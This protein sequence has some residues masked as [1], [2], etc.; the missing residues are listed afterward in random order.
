MFILFNKFLINTYLK[1]M[2]S[3]A[4]ILA[5]ADDLGLNSSVNQAILCCFEKG[6]INSTSLLTNTVH[7][8]E[9]V[10]LI[11]ANPVI[12]RIGVHVNL[13]GDKPVTNFNNHNY[14][15]E[16][17]NWDIKKTNKKLIFLST[18]DKSAFLKEI[19]AQIDRAL[20]S[21]IPIVHLDS[22]FHLHTLPGFY[23]L[24]LQA[25]EKYKIKLRLAQTYSEGNSFKFIYRKYINHKF[26]ANHINYSDYFETVDQF[27]KS[28]T[29]F[30]TTK[31]I[32]LMLHPDM[33]S[34]G[35]LTDHYDA[36]T[37]SNWIMFL[38]KSREFSETRQY[39]R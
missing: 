34:S 1:K 13:A 6:Y 7:F 9:T 11:H 33:D 21:Q 5:N 12:H 24:F 36:D 16:Y 3:T 15:D 37:M 22:H 19:Y 18:V 31:N 17:G 20:L 39:G 4:N 10:D 30:T 2:L 35:K 8:D 25:A 26:K 27:L 29:R 23:Q 32:E 28:T 14:L 38:D